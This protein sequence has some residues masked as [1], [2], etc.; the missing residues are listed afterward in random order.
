MFKH[1]Y[2]LGIERIKTTMI[3]TLKLIKEVMSLDLKASEKLTLISCIYKVS[4]AHWAADYPISIKSLC[5]DTN[6]PRA[7]LVR[8]LKTLEDLEYIKRVGTHNGNGQGASHLKVFPHKIMGLRGEAQNDTPPAHF[9]TPPSLK[10]IPPPAHFD[11]PPAQNESRNYPIS[12]KPFN[13]IEEQ[14]SKNN[15][16]HFSA[17]RWNQKTKVVPKDE[18]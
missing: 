1:R 12:S 18:Q 5:Q 6:Q 9:D 11:T 7:T 3:D 8:A 13:L 4:W 2:Y 10:M 14:T 16:S 15:D 17:K